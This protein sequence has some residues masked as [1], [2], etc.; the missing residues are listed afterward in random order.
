MVNERT[1][2]EKELLSYC[3]AWGVRKKE[4]K[5]EKAEEKMGK[6]EEKRKD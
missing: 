1:E 5:K 4:K 6:K 2:K 3:H